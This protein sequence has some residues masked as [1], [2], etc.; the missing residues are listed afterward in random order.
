MRIAKAFFKFRYRKE[1][2]YA[3]NAE[4]D[5]IDRIRDVS[6][7]FAE[8]CAEGQDRVAVIARSASLT[9]LTERLSDAR[10][11]WLGLTGAQTAAYLGLAIDSQ[12]KSCA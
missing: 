8:S 12:Y 1:S 7:L 11:Y 6:K 2:W 4:G 9:D 3:V 10:M 5:S